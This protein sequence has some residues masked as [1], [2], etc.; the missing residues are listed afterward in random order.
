MIKNESEVIEM[1]TYLTEE[2]QYQKVLNPNQIQRIKDP[3]LREIRSKH[4][5]Y[6]HKIFLDETH[7]SDQE[8]MRL[9]K[10]DEE[11]EQREIENYK[12][13]KK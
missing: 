10:L 8:L 7:I 11:A 9:Y 1:K 6:R 5:E 12:K 13:I 4:W 2:E 3:K